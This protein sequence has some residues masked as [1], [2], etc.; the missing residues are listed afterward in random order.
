MKMSSKIAHRNLPEFFSLSRKL[1]SARTSNRKTIPHKWMEII[2][3]NSNINFHKF[4][5]IIHPS[6]EFY[7]FIVLLVLLS[8]VFGGSRAFR[9]EN[10]QNF[11]YMKRVLD[12][13]IVF[14]VWVASKNGWKLFS[15]LFPHAPP[16]NSRESFF[17]GRSFNDKLEYGEKSNINYKRNF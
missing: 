15:T 8:R 1:T 7:E 17:V 16:G 6:L 9:N 13:I 5:I 10:T 12:D 4:R 3:I 2:F 14:F 11:F